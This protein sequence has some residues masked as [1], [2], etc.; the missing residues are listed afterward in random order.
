[1][2]NKE[3]A[4]IILAQLGGSKFVVMTGAY[5]FTSGELSLSMRLPTKL[6]KGVGGVRITLDPSDTYSMIAFKQKGSFAKG[7]FEVVESFNESGIYCD[8]LTDFFTEATGLATS[9]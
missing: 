8:Q 1:M 3:I 4:Q 7:N 6:T 5:S 9:L 2:T